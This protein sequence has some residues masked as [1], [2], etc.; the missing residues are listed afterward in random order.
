MDGVAH[1][2]SVGRRFHDR[3]ECHCESFRELLTN[4]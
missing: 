1:E 2:I 3:V 4:I